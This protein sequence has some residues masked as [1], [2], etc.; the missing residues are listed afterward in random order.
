MN[1]CPSEKSSGLVVKFQSTEDLEMATNTVALSAGEASV[2]RVSQPKKNT[3][4]QMIILHILKA[5][6][7]DDT[8]D[9]ILKKNTNINR[10]VDTGHVFSL[11]LTMMCE[12]IKTAVVKMFRK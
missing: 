2:L 1:S 6:S 3:L 9:S 10:L 5:M 12:D 11:V 7:E 8:Q 4:L